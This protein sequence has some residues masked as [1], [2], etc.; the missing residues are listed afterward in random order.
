[1]KATWTEPRLDASGAPLPSGILAVRP[2][3]R[4]WDEIA[5]RLIGRWSMPVR[6][7]EASRRIRSGKAVSVAGV[8]AGRAPIAF[9]ARVF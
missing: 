3:E 7:P 2:D 5:L 4:V 9:V 1:M 6:R 8:R